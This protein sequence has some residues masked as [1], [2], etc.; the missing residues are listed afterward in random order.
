MTTIADNPLLQTEGL[1]AFDRIEPTH[2]VE[3]VQA[4]LAEV[5]AAFEAIESAAEP[6]W[7]GVME[8]LEKLEARF[9]YFWSP[10]GHL[11]SVKNSEALR[12]AYEAVQP[13][14][15]AF[16]LRAGQSRPIYEALVAIRDGEGWEALRDAQRRAITLRIQA[17]E[18]SGVA[19]EGEAKEKFE[20]IA[21]ELSKL[22]T[23]FANHVLDA[24]KA[25]E[26]IVT[27]PADAEGWPESLRQIAAQSHRMNVEGSEATAD[28]GPW[29]VTLDYPC[30]GPFMEH[31]RNRSQ[32]EALYRA[33]ATKASTGD[34][35]NQPL[36]DRILELRRQKI[37]LLGFA[38]YADFSLDAKM[39][40]GVAAV[41]TMLNELAEAAKPIADGEMEE[42]RRFANEHGHEGELARW[43]VA[44]WAERLRETRFDFT[45][46]QLR[47]YFPLPRVLDGLFSLCTRLFG[48]TFE[49]TE[50]VAP[51]WQEDVRYYRVLDASGEPI[52]GFYLDPYARPA[53]KRGGAWMDQCLTRMHRDSGLQ[54]PVVHLVCNGTPPVDGKPSLMSFREV[55]TLFHEFGHGL[56]G[57]LTTVDVADV[58]GINGVEWDAVELASQF[59]ENWCYHKPTLVGMTGHVE[60]GEPLPDDLFEKIVAARTYRTGWMTLRQ[61]EFALT[62]LRLHHDAPAGVSPMDVHREISASL[63][64][65][66]L[67]PEDRF[68]CSFTHIFAGGYAAGYYSYK[69]AEVL[70]ADAFA[71]FEEVGLDNEAEV[72]ELGRT[73][74]DS[75]LALGGSRHPME[76]YRAFRGRDPQ[77]D[78]LLRHTG[79]VR[80]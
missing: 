6:T 37:E 40:P 53:D 57:M 63:A 62:D 20:A 26:L 9:A 54:L 30:L 7:A 10:V 61:V 73:Y 4:A 60:T 50:G 21:K 71:A 23:D 25:Y 49:L 31:S 13:E 80:P 51:V 35:D 3:G 17:A 41:R 55:E 19:L 38:N 33:S 18:R 1:P 68:L 27:D 69:W 14:V 66:P 67:L 32:R 22:T 28:A 75:V 36:I 70:S 77:I 58:A 47:P 79:L 72:S 78:A 8:P 45:D 11:M 46:E 39:A 44:F 65:M 48:V 52:A 29:R 15:V 74:R 12:E 64:P 2:V 56:Q 76:V 59:M 42:L 43:D 24:T 5:T 34:L 16:G